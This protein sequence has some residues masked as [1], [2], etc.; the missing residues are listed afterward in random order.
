MTAIPVVHILDR[1][2]PLCR[3]TT[4]VPGEWPDGHQWVGLDDTEPATCVACL[5]AVEQRQQVRR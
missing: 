3:F 4:D 5:K 1:G 2:L